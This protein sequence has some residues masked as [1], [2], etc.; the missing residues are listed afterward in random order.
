[1]KSVTEE[2]SSGAWRGRRDVKVSGALITLFVFDGRNCPDDWTSTASASLNLLLSNQLSP[3]E[4]VNS[5]PSVVHLLAR[6]TTHKLNLIH[7]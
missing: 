7:P 2:E 5:H 4:K 3:I 6:P 1:M